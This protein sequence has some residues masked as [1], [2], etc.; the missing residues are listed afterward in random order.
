MEQVLGPSSSFPLL[1][2]YDIATMAAASQYLRG[3]YITEHNRYFSVSAD[4]EGVPSCCSSPGCT[5][6]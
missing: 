3:V 1:R 5:I 6:S 2:L 4:E